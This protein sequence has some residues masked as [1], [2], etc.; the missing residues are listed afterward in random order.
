[1]QILEELYIGSVRPGERSGKRNAQ[2]RQALDDIIKADD[3]LR[4]TLSEEQKK[5]FEAYIEAQREVSI[6]TDLE[7]YIGEI[8]IEK[9]TSLTLRPRHRPAPASRWTHMPM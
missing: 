8:P 9:L 3:A 1:M 4:A 5:L 2:Y 6:L 7:T